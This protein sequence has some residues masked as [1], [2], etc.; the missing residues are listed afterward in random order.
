MVCY[1][2]IFVTG[3][4]AQYYLELNGTIIPD[5][6]STELGPP[7][8]QDLHTSVNFLEDILKHNTCAHSPSSPDSLIHS[9]PN[10]HSTAQIT[11]C[12]GSH[13]DTTV[14]KH[15]DS[16]HLGKFHQPHPQHVDPSA[17][18]FNTDAASPTADL[19]CEEAAG[20]YCKDAQ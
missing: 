13:Q 12:A 2:F 4:S 6:L 11:S 1:L 16:N 7:P 8:S 10:H 15:S 14:Y 19:A 9:F 18:W 20:K 5:K 3:L 17:I